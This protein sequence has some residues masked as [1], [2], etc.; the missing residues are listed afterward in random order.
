MQR[1]LVHPPRAL[2]VE[3]DEV[4]VG[5]QGEAAL[6]RPQAQTPRGVLAQKLR[7]AS[8]REATLDHRFVKHEREEEL[9]CGDAGLGVEYRQAFLAIPGPA[10][11]VGRHIGDGAARQQAPQR[12][13]LGG[14]TQRRVD[15]H[16]GALAAHLA[17][18][19]QQVV[20]AGLRGDVGAVAARSLDQRERPLQGRVDDVGPGAGRKRELECA[21]DRLGFGYRRA[22]LRMRGGVGATIRHQAGAQ[23]PHDVVVLCVKGDERPSGVDALHRE[24]QLTVRDAGEAHRVCLEG[25]HFETAGAGADQLLDL[26]EAAG[27]GDGRPQGDVGDGLA[28]HGRRLLDEGAD[29][30][31]RGRVVVRHVDDGR[32]SARRRRRG[33][34]REAFGR[35]AARVH[36]GVDHSR[37]NQAAAGVDAF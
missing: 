13:Q 30:G 19:H 36:V 8:D 6:L 22:A 5:A 9:E 24:I 2:R 3:D 18:V 11:V 12:L 35:L 14:G 33:G 26:V 1:R 10:D 34:A 15:L 4:G 32:D 28:I 25:R 23:A 31:D 21:S 16:A 27:L 29:V 7:Q 20:K 17:F 37:Q